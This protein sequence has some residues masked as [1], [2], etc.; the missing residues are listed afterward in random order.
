MKTVKIVTD[1]IDGAV[2]VTDE[3]DGKTHVGLAYWS[4][5][6]IPGRWVYPEWCQLAS[7][8]SSLSSIG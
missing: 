1:E 6:T 5:Q 2:I 7:S 4:D 3:I 8:P